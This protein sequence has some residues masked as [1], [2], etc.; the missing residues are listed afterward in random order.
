MKL[1]KLFEDIILED[2]NN[3]LT[4]SVDFNTVKDSIE[5]KYNINI[6]YIDGDGVRT[7]RYIQPYVLGDTLAGN[8][9]IRAY[10]IFGG[11]RTMATKGENAKGGWRI[12]RLDRI[13]DWKPTKMKFS[14]P[15]SDLPSYMINNGRFNPN[16]DKMFSS[17]DAIATFGGQTQEPIKV[18]VQKQTQVPVQKQTQEPIQ[19]SKP[20]IKSLSPKPSKPEIKTVAAKT[21]RYSTGKN[22]KPS[23]KP[24]KPIDTSKTTSTDTNKK[25]L[26]PIDK[27]EEI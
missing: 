10:Q 23:I 1:Y 27:K 7:T 3:L 2:K 16:G 9:A 6:V 8:K 14:V 25:V 24:E 13:V 19:P 22:P 18:P 15:V 4:E 11:S 12:F 20:E 26:Q 21:N 5:Q 17:V